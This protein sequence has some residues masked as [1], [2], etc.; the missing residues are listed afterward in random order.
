MPFAV[1][2]LIDVFL[3][4]LAM[5]II[6]FLHKFSSGNEQRRME[7]LEEQQLERQYSSS[8]NS[9]LEGKAR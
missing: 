1:D 7:S 6:I 3:F 8:S 5:D 2:M 4:F 9:Y